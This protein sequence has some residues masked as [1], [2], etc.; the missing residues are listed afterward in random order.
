M[1]F[2]K[3]RIFKVRINH[4]LSDSKEQENGTANGSILNP[5][6]FILK[7]NGIMK[8]IPIDCNLTASLYIDDVMITYSHLDLITAQQSLQSC[9]N[10]IYS[11][12]DRNGFTFSANK[13]VAIHFTD[14]PG[15]HP[16]LP[17][18]L[19]EV[20]IDY[21]DR[22]KFLGLIFGRKLTW[23][24]FLTA[25]KNKCNSVNNLLKS[26]SALEWGA[27]QEC[28]LR[29]YKALLCSRLDYGCAVYCSAPPTS[30]K[31]L[32]PMLTNV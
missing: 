29:I 8:Q 10:K 6:L 12:A 31:I 16:S 32:D 3:D 30:L 9:I 17:L 2:F 7:I 15:I 4:T 5:T 28:I 27:D 22:C 14:K 18:N 26:I 25:L 19:K 20:N 1:N 11:W 13:T 23:K 24:P 21:S